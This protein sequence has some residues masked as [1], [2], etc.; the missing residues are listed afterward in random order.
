MK[1]M[2]VHREGGRGY[3]EVNDRT[4][5]GGIVKSLV[6]HG[7]WGWGW[8]CEVDDGTQGGSGRDCEVSDSTHGGRGR[9]RVVL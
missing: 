1:S 9:G 5:G 2:I 8:Y 3:C 6:V 4:Q 7:G